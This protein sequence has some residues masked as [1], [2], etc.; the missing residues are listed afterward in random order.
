MQTGNAHVR[1]LSFCWDQ[2]VQ[3][4]ILAELEVLYGKIHDRRVL[5]REKIVARE[6]LDVENNVRRQRLDLVR[7]LQPLGALENVLQYF[8]TS[9][10][11][12]KSYQK[13]K[14]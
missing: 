1:Q 6:A 11:V 7:L 5:L 12:R 4:Q 10:L 3:V 13:N 8:F 9:L 14:V 2:L